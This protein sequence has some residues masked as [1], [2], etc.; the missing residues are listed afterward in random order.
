MDVVASP[1]IVGGVEN[2]VS[3]AV[4]VYNPVDPLFTIDAAKFVATVVVAAV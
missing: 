3:V 1:S 2:A 4:V